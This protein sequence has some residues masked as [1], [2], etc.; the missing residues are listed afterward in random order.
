MQNLQFW[1][2]EAI[3]RYESFIARD[4]TY[5]AYGHLPGAFL[6]LIETEAEM[7]RTKQYESL[8]RRQGKYVNDLKSIAEMFGCSKEQAA[9]LGSIGSRFSWPYTN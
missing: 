6:E 4:R 1:V 2:N 3:L 7:A 9:M 5:E 8:I